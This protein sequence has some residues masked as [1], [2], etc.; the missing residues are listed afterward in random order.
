M[1]YDDLSDEEVAEYEASAKNARDAIAA[2]VEACNH[3]S[4]TFEEED[5]ENGIPATMICDNCVHM[6]DGEEAKERR[7]ERR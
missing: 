4:M 6:I 1:T 2:E 3:E 5:E 7:D